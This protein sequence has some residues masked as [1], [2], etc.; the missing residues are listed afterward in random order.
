M[1]NQIL[2]RFAN[3][4]DLLGRVLIAFVF[5]SAGFGKI[6]AGFEGTQGYMDAM[7]VPGGLLP[8][9]ILLEIG[10]GVLIA[11][12]LFIR[13]AAILLAGFC[14]VSA[15]LFHYDPENQMQMIMFSKNLA[16][17][18]GLL[19]FAASGARGWSLDERRAAAS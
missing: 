2:D 15:V 17:A 12:G 4:L 8:L 7:G 11:I 5:V 16:I 19:A 10:A 18:G 9:V 1:L 6:G 3:P 14:V 13:P